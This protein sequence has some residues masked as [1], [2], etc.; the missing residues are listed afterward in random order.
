LPASEAARIM[1]SG[2]NDIDTK[3]FEEENEEKGESIED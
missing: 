1:E 2:E 3:D